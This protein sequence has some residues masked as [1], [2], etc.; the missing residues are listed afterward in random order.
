MLPM[1][2]PKLVLN[3]LY[4]DMNPQETVVE[5]FFQLLSRP[6]KLVNFEGGHIP[7]PEIAVPIVKPWLDE[8]LGPV[9]RKEG[10]Q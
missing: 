4:D 8:T 7:P 1:A 2:P 6:K 3:G 10:Q 9:S 5:P